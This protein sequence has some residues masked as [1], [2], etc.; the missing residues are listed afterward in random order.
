MK[1]ILLLWLEESR[2]CLAP[3]WD[4]L[5]KEKKLYYL[6]HPMIAIDRMFR[7]LEEKLLEFPYNPEKV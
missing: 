2:G 7:W 6:I 5:T 3:L 4:W 1:T